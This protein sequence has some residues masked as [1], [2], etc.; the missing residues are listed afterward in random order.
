MIDVLLALLLA[1]EAVRYNLVGKQS[2]VYSC[3][4]GDFFLQT[5]LSSIYSGNAHD[6]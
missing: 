2:E 3:G 6:F 4:N 1:F 5:S